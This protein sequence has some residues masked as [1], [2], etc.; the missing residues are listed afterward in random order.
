MDHMIGIE[1]AF[2]EEVLMRILAFLKVVKEAL[3]RHD[4]AR[5]KGARHCLN[6]L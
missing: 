3:V 6:S 1:F 2:S 5:I 4:M